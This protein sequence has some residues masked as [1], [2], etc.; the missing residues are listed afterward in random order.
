MNSFK[1]RASLAGLLALGASAAAQAADLPAPHM[2]MPA[3]VEFAGG[4][5][6]RG[7]VGVSS[8]DAD[9]F[10]N[11]AITGPTYYGQDFGSGSFAG[12][13]VGY[14]FSN[15]FRADVTGEY[16]FST[17]F[18]VLDREH[19]FN[20]SYGITGHEKTKGE[21]DAGVFMVNGYFDLGTWYGITPFVGAGVG[22]ARLSMHGFE[23][24]TLNIYDDPTI[25]TGVSGGTIR[26]SHKGNL[27]W[28]LHAGLAYDVTPNVKL[29]LAYRYLNLGDATTGAV[30]CFCGTTYQG[31]KVKELASHDFKVGMRW[32]FGGPV[33]QPVSYDAPII[34]KY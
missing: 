16:R 8:Y 4:W 10:N 23:T 18:R 20:G 15:W 1:L 26:D 2:P 19:Y 33:A 5:Y 13:G 3:P 31:Y 6:L 9:K 14:Q 11:P 29:E 17:G 12:A 25:G 21:F 30:D 7:D 28:A 24:S 27:A 22:Y 34:R 32:M